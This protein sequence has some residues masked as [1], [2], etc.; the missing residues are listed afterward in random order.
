MSSIFCTRSNAMF[1]PF[2]K[3]I[4]WPLSPQNPVLRW[5]PESLWIHTPWRGLTPTNS[6]KESA[7]EPNSWLS[8]VPKQAFEIHGRDNNLES[9]GFWFARFAKGALFLNV[10]ELVLSS[11]ALDSKAN[12]WRNLGIKF[13]PQQTIHLRGNWWKVR[14]SCPWGW[15]CPKEKEKKEKKKTGRKNYKFQ[16]AKKGVK[17]GW[18][19]AEELIIVENAFIILFSLFVFFFFFK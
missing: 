17:Q 8:P 9:Q 16:G 11:K 7:K 15:K 2:W 3:G 12:P 14:L 1:V 6:E 19:W 13:L 18:L 10:S 5:R 4:L